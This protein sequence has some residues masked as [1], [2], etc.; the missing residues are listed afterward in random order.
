MF[1]IAEQTALVRGHAELSSDFAFVTEEFRDGWNFV[2]FGDMRRLEG[3]IGIPRWRLSRI[4]EASLKSGV[5]KTPQEAI[6]S[7]LKLALRRVDDCFSVAEVERIE[8]T[9]YPWFVL[10]RVTVYP[11]QMGQSALVSVFDEALPL[12]MPPPVEMLTIPGHPR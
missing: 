11:C 1:K 7:A 3:G 12:P 6:A 2:L 9:K 5:G 8:L 10:A 4:A